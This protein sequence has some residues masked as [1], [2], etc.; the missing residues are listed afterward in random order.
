MTRRLMR[1]AAPLSVLVAGLLAGHFLYA[2]AAAHAHVAVTSPIA[3]RSPSGDEDVQAGSTGQLQGDGSLSDVA[4]L[5]DKDV[6]AVG[7]QYT[8]DF[9]RNRGVIT[10]WDGTSWSSVSVHGDTT[11][12]GHLRS[13]A[14]PVAN[15]V[16]AV[17]DGHDG[18]PYVARGSLDGFDRVG[19]PQFRP[20]DWVG[21]VAATAS[22]VVTVGSRDGHAFMVASGG[23]G[24]GTVW[25]TSK[26]PTGTLYG[27]AL[28]GKTDG[29]A[30]GDSGTDPLVMRLTG[31]GWKPAAL[32]KIKGGFLR[33]VYADGRK[34][35]IAIGGVYDAGG[36]IEPLV[37]TW[38][39][40]RWKRES[41]PEHKAE[42]Y[43]VTGDG[44]GTFWMSGYDPAH[45][46]EGF[47]LR[48]DGSR[49]ATL[50]E[51]TSSEDRTVRLQ[52]IARVDDQT[53]TVG[54]ALDGKDHY[55]DLVERI[56]PPSEG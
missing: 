12:A 49:W 56:G 10:H 46:A 8:W 2:T 24:K 32:P 15:E 28:A 30:V 34:Q 13:I 37:L 41:P 3:A 1:R 21:G 39:G 4:A 20:G 52:A 44:D 53:I 55:S 22:R 16:W 42:L 17:G 26:G 23:S 19:V 36:A 48:F 51:Q 25:T 14:A 47:V 11:G 7:Q 18:L 31:D 6:W 54:H 5:S 33:D 50:R 27:V 45:P 40:K 38:D 9:W 43:G 29:W 35:A